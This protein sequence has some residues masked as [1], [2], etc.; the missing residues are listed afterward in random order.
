MQ[1]LRKLLLPLSWFYGLILSLRHLFYNTGILKVY[2]PSQKT[3]I[4]GN[5]S[6]GG[7][8]KTPMVDYL[9]SLMEIDKVAVLSRGYGRT[10]KGTLVVNQSMA[11]AQ[12]G[13]EPLLL[14]NK[15]PDLY[16]MVDESRARGLEYLKKNRPEIHTVILDDAMQHRKVKADFSL[17]LTTWDRPFSSDYLLPAGNLRDIKSRS[18]SAQAIV[19]TKTPFESSQ[20][21]QT[22]LAKELSDEGQK[23]F[24]SRIAYGEVCNLIHGR[25]IEPHVSSAVL[26][27]AIANPVLF[28]QEA[29]ERFNVLKHFEFKDHHLFRRE[30]LFKLRD[31]I[32]TFGAEKPIILT[33]EKDAQ[34]LKAHAAF[35]QE[36]QISVFYWKIKP[37]FGNDAEKFNSMILSI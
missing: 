8:G 15:H 25:P 7:T 24:F 20:N 35:F 33:T 13:D 10:T 26:L 2:K 9:V 34:R 32:D 18:K 23:V 16:V 14:K 4:V 37:D 19:V 17:L 11:A 5:L 28:E 21:D 30:E 6:L 29:K 27:T 36:N 22:R 12:C 31:F 3:I 1:E